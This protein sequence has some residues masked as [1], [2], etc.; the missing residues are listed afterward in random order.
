MLFLYKFLIQKEINHID[1]QNAVIIIPT[2]ADIVT[3]D[4]LRERIAGQ[5]EGLIF[6]DCFSSVPNA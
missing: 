3:H 5:R 1:I 4:D 2:L 6:S